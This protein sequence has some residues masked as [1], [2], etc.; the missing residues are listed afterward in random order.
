[1]HQRKTEA[2]K[3]ARACAPQA[4]TTRKGTAMSPHHTL[5]PARTP[6]P[7]LEPMGLGTPYVEKL[8]SYLIRVATHSH[9]RLSALVKNYIQSPNGIEYDCTILVA[10]HKRLV[11]AHGAMA[12]A[13]V[14]S[15]NRMVGRDDLDLL[16]LLPW[17]SIFSPNCQL[18]NPARRWCPDCLDEDRQG[19]IPAYERLI[20]SIQHVVMCPRHHRYFVTRCPSCAHEQVSDFTARQL[21]GFCSACGA[22]LGTPRHAPPQPRSKAIPDCQIWA[23]EVLADLLHHPPSAKL[24]AHRARV[25]TVTDA[26][27]EQIFGGDMAALCQHLGIRE[28]DISFWRHGRGYPNAKFLLALSYCFR[29][30]LRN[31]LDGQCHL[32]VDREIRP[33]P[34]TAPAKKNR[35]RTTRE[36]ERIRLFLQQI[37]AGQ[38]QVRSLSHAARI[39]GVQSWQLNHY[40]PAISSEVARIAARDH[41]KSREEARA[42]RD[43]LLYKYVSA[44]I[45]DMVRAG[46]HPTIC[47]L[48]ALAR[49]QRLATSSNED[50]RRISQIRCAVLH[51]E[52]LP[53]LEPRKYRRKHY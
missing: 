36:W 4:E 17:S 3:I 11:N 40:F 28:S 37:I 26:L 1:M 20:W 48:H 25:V 7:N 34:H 35:L 24:D 23:T 42:I 44:Q 16:T 52:P 53:C 9:I 2:E 41:A 19:R 29:I 12:G 8:T 38:C 30:T 45:R 46:Q 6:F 49:A 10:P 5:M 21:N 31:L 18:I 32:R 33:L 15:A 43:K 51:D 14:T 39:L 47:Y 22:W 50:I 27:C 13:W